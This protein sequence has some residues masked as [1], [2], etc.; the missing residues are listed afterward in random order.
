[1]GIQS[2]GGLTI[3]VDA[4]CV[5]WESVAMKVGDL[6]KVK[7]KHYGIELGVLVKK[8]RL[9][10][11]HWQVKMFNHPRDIFA[12]PNDLEVISESR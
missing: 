11:E 9:R 7:T 5:D 12:M 8:L 2:N 3:G 6:V 1:M 10:D 4:V